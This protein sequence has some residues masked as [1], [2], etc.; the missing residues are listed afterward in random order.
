MK[1]KGHN[2]IVIRRL[3]G[4]GHGDMVEPGHLLLLKYI[5]TRNEN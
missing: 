2:D 1:L 4:F 3:D 5:R